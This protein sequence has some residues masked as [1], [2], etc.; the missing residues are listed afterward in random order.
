M[1]GVD[2]PIVPVLIDVVPGL[3]QNGS[4]LYK[5]GVGLDSSLDSSAQLF[6]KQL[7]GAEFRAACW[8]I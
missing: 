8:L 1:H 2:E 6:L 4:Q 3:E 5:D 7:D